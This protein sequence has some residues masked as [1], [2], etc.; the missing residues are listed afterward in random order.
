MQG[1][2]L[3]RTRD[4][5][6]EPLG[7]RCVVVAEGS[8]VHTRHDVGMKR[9]LRSFLDTLQDDS[10]VEECIQTAKCDMSSLQLAICLVAR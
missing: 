9:Q 2:Q 1:K 5:D 7:E 10:E 4:L 8:Q 3:R 6:R